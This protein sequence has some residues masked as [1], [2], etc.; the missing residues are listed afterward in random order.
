MLGSNSMAVSCGNWDKCT[1]FVFSWDR[2][3]SFTHTSGKM[4]S[5]VQCKST[6]TLPVPS[7]LLASTVLWKTTLW[8]LPPLSMWV[9]RLRQMALWRSASIVWTSKKSWGLGRDHLRLFLSFFLLLIPALDGESSFNLD[10][11]DILEELCW[12][13]WLGT[14]RAN[15]P[16]EAKLA[17]QPPTTHL[18]GLSPLWVSMCLC[19]QLWLVD[20]VLYTLQPFHRQTNTWKMDTR[21]EGEKKLDQQSWNSGE[22]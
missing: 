4:S 13:K 19:S 8:P 15:P 1:T 10:W 5:G 18:K 14:W 7:F 2:S 6:F 12:L 11:L 17:L 21:T 16:W 3:V 20:G 9:E 22:N